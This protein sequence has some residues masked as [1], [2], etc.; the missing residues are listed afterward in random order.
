MVLHGS[1]PHGYN[2]LAIA[3]DCDADMSFPITEGGCP[4]R[5]KNQNNYI[6]SLVIP[7]LVVLE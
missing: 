6:P 2:C 4:D 1:E 3:M 5:K 7:G